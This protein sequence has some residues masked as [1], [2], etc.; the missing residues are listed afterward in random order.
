MNVFL[1]YHINLFVTKNRTIEWLYLRNI[2]NI[3]KNARATRTNVPSMK[4]YIC[5][6][7]LFVLFVLHTKPCS[8]IWLSNDKWSNDKKTKRKNIYLIFWSKI[9]G[10]AEQ[11][12]ECKINS[13]EQTNCV[14]HTDYRV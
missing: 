3:P 11:W 5:I 4:Y 2:I 10:S 9:T 8:R 7:L 14:T 13:C 1:D 12:N 6:V